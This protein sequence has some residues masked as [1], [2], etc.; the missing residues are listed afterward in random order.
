MSAINSARLEREGRPPSLSH[1]P[2]LL[3]LYVDVIVRRYEAVTGESAVPVETGETFE[4]IGAPEGNGGNA[5]LRSEPDELTR[6]ELDA[7]QTRPVLSTAMRVEPEPRNGSS[8]RMDYHCLMIPQFLRPAQDAAWVANAGVAGPL[9]P[10]WRPTSDNWVSR[11]RSRSPGF[12][13]HAAMG[14]DRAGIRTVR[15]VSGSMPPKDDL[16]IE[17]VCADGPRARPAA[18]GNTSADRT[19]R[20]ET[21]S[22]V[23]SIDFAWKGAAKLRGRG[24][25]RGAAVRGGALAAGARVAD[26]KRRHR[27]VASA[28]RLPDKILANSCADFSDLELGP[29]GR[30]YLLSDKSSTIARLDDLPPGGGAAAILEACRLGHLE[31][32]PEGFVFTAQGRA[33]VGLDPRKP[34]RNLLLLELAVAE[35]PGGGQSLG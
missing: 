26:Q 17:A 24:P 13:C 18:P 28:T 32:T 34:R 15:K 27:F 23:A 16:Q 11:R 29:D 10:E 2:Q 22:V 19:H 4:P 25:I 14:P 30:L 7:T 5:G 33:V 3:P 20:P 12:P 31:G 35:L 6:I 1:Q 8:K 9:T 21:S